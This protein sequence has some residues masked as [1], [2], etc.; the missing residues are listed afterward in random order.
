MEPPDAR[1][2]RSLGAAILAKS[3]T[4]GRPEEPTQHLSP[5][6]AVTEVIDQA[7]STVAGICWRGSC[8]GRRAPELQKR[9]SESVGRSLLH[10][11]SHNVEPH[12]SQVIAY[13]REL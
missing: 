3:L 1:L 8:S 6:E 11:G 7:N 4:A 12:V 5:T 9:R 10:G 2:P 13:R